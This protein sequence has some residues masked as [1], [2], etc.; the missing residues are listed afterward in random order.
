MA[1]MKGE[2]ETKEREEEKGEGE[3]RTGKKNDEYREKQEGTSL[4][5]RPKH[6]R[7]GRVE[8]RLRRRD[9]AT[10]WHENWKKSI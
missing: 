3:T 9:V 5:E 1:G 2:G 7:V 6:L 10:P 8:S 4:L